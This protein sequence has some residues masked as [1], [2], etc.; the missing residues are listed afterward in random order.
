MKATLISIALL[1][2]SH[3]FAQTNGDNLT[4]KSGDSLSLYFRS[5]GD[6]L[7]SYIYQY[8]PTSAI[9]LTIPDESPVVYKGTVIFI[10]DKKGDMYYDPSLYCK[11]IECREHKGLKLFTPNK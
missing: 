1:I 4:L 9:T 8:G 10:L 11:C 5:T 3:A 6:S 7:V 2:S